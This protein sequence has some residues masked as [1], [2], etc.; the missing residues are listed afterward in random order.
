MAAKTPD[1]SAIEADY[2]VGRKPLRTI[3][4]EHGITHGA[5]RKRA[6]RDGWTRD[7]SERIRVKAQ[8][9]VSKDAVSN[10]VSKSDERI[11]VD[12]AA[13]LQADIIRGQ[14][15]DVGRSREIVQHM[16]EELAWQNLLA[17]DIDKIVEAVKLLTDEDDASGVDKV[18]D[19]LL[20]TIGLPTR[21]KGVSQ[22]ADALAKLVTLER[23]IFGI[24]K[25]QPQAPMASLTDDQ[26]D[27]LIRSKAAALGY[28]PAA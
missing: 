4:D 13:T 16:I 21:I 11:L 20:A 2:R 26:L 5:I 18:M 9:L 14:R 3:A 27:S 23:S 10:L 17:A 25:E 12:A 19:K 28:T 22:L 1:W 8:A 24:E 7:L 6:T 15:R